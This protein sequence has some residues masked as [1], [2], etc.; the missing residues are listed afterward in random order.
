MLIRLAEPLPT[1][2]FSP[3][4]RIAF[5][6]NTTASSCTS[7]RWK[8]ALGECAHV[9]SHRQQAPGRGG[10]RPPLTCLWEHAG[11]FGLACQ[12]LR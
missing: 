12:V 8:A 7:P 11:G 2:V 4:L 5:L 6:S 10:G 3:H 9:G 1:A